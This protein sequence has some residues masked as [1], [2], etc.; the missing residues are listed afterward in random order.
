MNNHA[1]LLG[2]EFF[3]FSQLIN[4]NSEI[5]DYMRSG[6]KS[7]LD[8]RDYVSAMNKMVHKTTYDHMFYRELFLLNMDFYGKLERRDE[9]DYLF[10][11]NKKSLDELEELEKNKHF[12]KLHPPIFSIH[13][14]PESHILRSRPMRPFMTKE[15]LEEME[16]DGKLEVK[17]Y[18]ALSPNAMPPIYDVPPPGNL[19]NPAL[20][21]LGI[22]MIS[23]YT[24]VDE[25]RMKV[26]RG[27]KN[28]SGG[29][30]VTRSSLFSSQP[31]YIFNLQTLMGKFVR[32]AGRY[33]DDNDQMFNS[34][35]CFDSVGS[36]MDNFNLNICNGK[37]LSQCV[38]D[39]AKKQM[40]GDAAASAISSSGLSSDFTKKFA[41]L[42]T[43]I[44]KLSA[45]I[46]A[47]PGGPGPAPAALAALDTKLDILTSGVN[48]KV[49]EMSLNLKQF[50]TSDKDVLQHLSDVLTS[51]R[52][53]LNKP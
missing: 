38:V 29:D 5:Y 14:N 39:I 8:A 7:A 34:R 28:Q 26:S 44:T 41:D 25:L 17:E 37:D 9:L 21:S 32:L 3:K 19:T 1:D 6:L 47:A 22:G 27:G 30:F 53:N 45:A 35:E 40:E 13:S 51:L 31:D 49:N 4:I 20:D 11:I 42:T 33:C 48:E 24:L 2:H 10:Q 18:R 46:T 12:V 52:N 50:V 23:P 15:K 43:Q 16:K 36:A